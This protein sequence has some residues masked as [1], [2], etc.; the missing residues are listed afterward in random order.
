MTALTSRKKSAALKWGVIAIALIALLGLGYYFFKPKETAPN[1]ITAEAVMGDIEE[2]IMASGKVKALKSV[3]V[4]SQVSG[5]VKTLHVQLG[6][7]VKEGDLIAQIDEVTQSNNLQ[8]ARANLEQTQASLQSA[9]A[10]LA[11]RQ[12]DVQS[13]I[14]TIKTREAELKKAQTQLERLTPLIAID[15][16][17]QKEYDDARAEVEVASANLVSAQVALEN[18]KSSV[19]SANAEITNAHANIKKSQ[20]DLSTAETNLGYT[21]I[22]APIAGTVVKV[23]TEQG[24]TVNS[25]SSTPNIVTL[26]D[27]S[28]VRINAQISEADVINI[29]A[30][31]PAKFNIIGNPDQKFDA[32]LTGIEP[33]P[34]TI[35]TSSSTSSAVYYIGYLDVDNSEG[36]FR[37]DMTAQVNIIINQVKDVLTVPAA[38]IR[39]E[40]GKSTVKVL[41]ADGTAEAVAVEVGLNNRITAEIKSG[42]KAGDKVIVSESGADG[43]AGGRRPPMM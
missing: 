37:I 28:R 41:K 34:E 6:D 27:L 4:G 5:E 30:G 16:I 17:S 32:I 14:A 38:A 23:T 43:N 9:K 42:L 25:S 10:A 31:M 20:N 1:Y 7:T 3:D 8:N 33:A 29:Q 21:T 19:H 11:S 2:S 36:R 35:S 39:T 13:A 18:A 22:R 12:G 15:A 40:N 26:A 24:T